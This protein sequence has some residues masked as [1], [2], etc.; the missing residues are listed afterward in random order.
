MGVATAI[1]FQPTGGGKAAITGD[2]V[3]RGC[4]VNPVIRALTRPRHR[5]HRAAQPHDRRGAAALLHALLGE[6]RRGHAGEGTARRARSHEV[7]EDVSSWTT[8][9]AKIAG[10]TFFRIIANRSGRWQ[11]SITIGTC[12]QRLHRFSDEFNDG[13]FGLGGCFG[14]NLLG[15]CRASATTQRQPR[16]SAAEVSAGPATPRHPR[17]RS[18]EIRSIRSIRRNPFTNSSWISDVHT[19]TSSSPLQRRQ[20]KARSGSRSPC[21]WQRRHPIRAHSTK[22]HTTTRIRPDHSAPFLPNGGPSSPQARSN[23]GRQGQVVQR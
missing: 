18:K 7:E 16:S 21:Q 23:A 19:H 1:N 4:E 20:I 2:F 9:S 13:C 14:Y 11:A 3:L 12:G 15:D 8:T 10:A 6:R 22:R 17:D 5:G